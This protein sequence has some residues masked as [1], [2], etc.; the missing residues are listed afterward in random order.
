MPTPASAVLTDIRRRNLRQIDLAEKLG[1]GSSYLSQ[2]ETGARKMPERL[3]Q[4][5]AVELK[6]SQGELSAL[7]KDAR[8]SI[9]HRVVPTQASPAEYELVNSLWDELGQLGENQIKAI[10][11][12]LLTNSTKEREVEMTT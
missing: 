2:L 6:L 1:I 8:I 5:M 10:Q 9:R 4:R 12:V 3:I 11:F 7:V